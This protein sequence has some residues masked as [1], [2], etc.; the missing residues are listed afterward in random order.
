MYEY[1]VA[2][3]RCLNVLTIVITIVVTVILQAANIIEALRS[4]RGRR[5]SN[6]PKMVKQDTVSLGLGLRDYLEFPYFPLLN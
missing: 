3:K 4:E 2:Q 1:L 6:L 5:H